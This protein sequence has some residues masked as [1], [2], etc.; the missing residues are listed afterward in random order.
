M[1]T[2]PLARPEIIG[3]AGWRDYLALCKLRVV[4]VMLLTLVVGMC[5]ATPELPSLA[6]LLLTN[7]GVGLAAASAAAVNHVLDQSIDARMART[8]RRPLPQ[9]KVTPLQAVVFAASLGVAGITV[10]ALTVNPLTAWLTLGS[11]IGYAFVYTAFLKR[12]TPQNIVIGG[13]AGAAPPLIGWVAVTGQVTA[14]GLLLMLIIFAWTPPHFWALCIARKDDY[15][16]A[17][18]PMLPIT[19][20]ESFTRL[21]I[22]LYTLLTVLLTLLPYFIGLSGLIYLVCVLILD[23]RLLYWAWRLYSAREVADP[24]KMFRFSILYI[25]ALF[26]ILLVDHY[27]KLQL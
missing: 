21:Q 27:L 20:G 7:I 23:A 8:A 18:V 13:V 6:L 2:Y 3:K 26:A 9:G 12:A 17:G 10:L 11:L 22:L 25:M 1:A 15:A 16:R 19:H 24:M 5:L 4:A 14:D